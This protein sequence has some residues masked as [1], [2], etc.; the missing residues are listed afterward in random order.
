MMV[1]FFSSLGNT[2]GQLDSETA[3]RLFDRPDVMRNS[4]L[5]EQGQVWCM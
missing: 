5:L 4:Q 2:K 1:L 3:R